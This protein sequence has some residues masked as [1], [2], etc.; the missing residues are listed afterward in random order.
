MSDST[1][2][3]LHLLS[4]LAVEDRLLDALLALEQVGVFASAPANAHGFAHGTLSTAEQVTGRSD[5]VLV[6]VLLSENKLN[7]L[8]ASLQNELVHSGVRYWVTP[9][10]RQGEFQ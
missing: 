8:L 6:Q 9:V 2:C 5:A 7:A 1:L 4:P 10:T 3:N